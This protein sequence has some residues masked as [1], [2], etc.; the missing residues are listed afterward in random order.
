MICNNCGYQLGEDNKFCPNCGAKVMDSQITEGQDQK[1]AGDNKGGKSKYRFDFEEI[2][3]DLDGYPTEETKRTEEVDFNWGP[4]VDDHDNKTDENLAE[5][6]TDEKEQSVEE[7]IF[8][9]KD[10]DGKISD[11]IRMS[12]GDELGKTT[13]MEKFYTY[14]KKSEEFQE[15]LGKEYNRLKSQMDKDEAKTLEETQL[16]AKDSD[17]DINSNSPI[18]ETPFGELDGEP[19][20]DFSEI[21]FLWDKEK[22]NQDGNLN[23]KNTEAEE[24]ENSLADEATDATE[25]AQSNEDMPDYLASLTEGMLSLEQ[26][27]KIEMERQ[28][29]TV[30]RLS[31]ITDDSTSLNLEKDNIEA[32]VEK[33]ISESL[34]I[35]ELNSMSAVT[36]EESK[37][38]ENSDDLES[39]I[40]EI[41]KVAENITKQ[42][43]SVLL[44]NNSDLVAEKNDEAEVVG[45]AFA[46]APQGIFA[47]ERAAE[48]EKSQLD[49]ETLISEESKPQISEP[50][51]I[52]ENTGFIPPV[53]EVP[54]TVEEIS[55]NESNTPDSVTD[56]EGE[57]TVNSQ[58]IEEMI[59]EDQANG[60]AAV[61]DN[62]ITFQDVFK[63][64]IS[65][66]KTRDKLQPKKHTALKVIAIILCILIVLEVVALVIKNVAPDSGA[67][68]ALQNIFNIIY[69]KIAGIFG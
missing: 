7:V 10:R 30:N 56:D 19:A 40:S 52:T 26:L 15:L 45:V 23:T 36:T 37:P 61:D 60:I 29:E 41:T 53:S 67:A 27:L 21:D 66:E 11:T 28:E 47:E 14:D 1:T 33:M 13:R 32:E 35:E 59:K 34:P 38:E 48:I 63:D 31:G 2:N 16:E 54:E 4:V 58:S 65:A 51:T 43:E 3:W 44:A 50:D 9:K 46:S 69:G 55:A 62:R 6:S 8:G 24:V 42:E 5:G 64:E 57:E 49:L 39:R 25:D 17:T 18:E 22:E 20:I 68:I 12:D